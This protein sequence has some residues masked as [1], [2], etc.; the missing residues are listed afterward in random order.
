MC[1]LCC[2]CPTFPQHPPVRFCLAYNIVRH[3]YCV[4][5]STEIHVLS[6]YVWNTEDHC[7]YVILF[8][9][10]I[11]LECSIFRRPCVFIFLAKNV[12]H[13][14]ITVTD[15]KQFKTSSVKAVKCQ[16]EVWTRIVSAEE[17]NIKKGFFFGGTGV[18]IT[19]ILLL[20]IL[21]LKIYP[22]VI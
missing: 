1:C 20:N 13:G 22:A 5:R 10:P 9:L 6:K 8:T 19:Y 18:W 2:K 12:C 3:I 4:G 21:V 16:R 17:M 11:K 15:V 14:L 7:A